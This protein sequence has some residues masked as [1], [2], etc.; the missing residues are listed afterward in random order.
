VM[1]TTAFVVGTLA[2]GYST[3][4]SAPYAAFV[5]G[6]VLLGAAGATWIRATR[7]VARLTR[8]REELDRELGT[9]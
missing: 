8:R 1:F 5:M 2:V 3:G 6:L 7:N 9:D 4:G